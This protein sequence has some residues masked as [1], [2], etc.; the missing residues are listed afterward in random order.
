MHT[1]TMDDLIFDLG[2]HRGEDSD[3]Y[4]KL[5]YRVVAVEANPALVAE[6][7]QRFHREIAEGIYTVV[8]KA[9]ADDA[10]VSF[11][12][13]R[14]MSIWGTTDLN[15]V[16]RNRRLGTESDEIKVA[17]ITIPALISSYGCPRY[18]KIDLEGIDV[19]CVKALHG[20]KCRPV[21]MSIESSK[22]SW[23]ELMT[24]LDELEELG[25]SKFKV[26]NQ[27][28]HKGG[29][30]LSRSG[31]SVSHAFNEHSSGPFGEYLDGPWLSKRETILHY[32]P[33]HVVYKTIGDNTLSSRVVRRIPVVRGLLDNL[34][35]WY[36]THAMLG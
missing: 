31:S 25:Y 28:K 7:R 13:N 11:Y 6:L 23:S 24:E 32:L 34:V 35:S 18:L 8:D 27:R 12:V 22:T 9:V 36:D 16:E 10:E 14:D 19:K 17:G 5:G 15:W 20:L 2:A 30:F 26:V 4:L 21:Y 29:V 33:I 1:M 3:F